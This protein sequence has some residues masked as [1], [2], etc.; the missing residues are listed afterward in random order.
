M[1]AAPPDAKPPISEKTEALQEARDSALGANVHSFDPDA[2]P[3]EKKA[4]ALK[5]ASNVTPLDL[6]AAPSLKRA[7]HEAFE[8]A[9][10]SSVSSDIGTKGSQIPVTTGL[11]DVQKVN[12]EE[13]SKEGEVS[14][15]DR[16]KEIAKDEGRVDEDGQDL[17]PGN[18][19]NKEAETGKPREIPSWF[20]I[21]WNGQ[22]QSLF[23]TPEESRQHAILADFVSEAYYGQWYVMSALRLTKYHNAG[24]IIFAVIASHFVTLFGGGWGWLIIVLAFCATYY[25][26]SIK[27][28]RRNARDDLARE[29]A[30]K[31]L[32]NEVETAAWINSFMQRF[33]LIYEPVLS[34]TI[35]A[36]VDQVLS[37]STPAFLDSLRMTTFTLGTKPPHIDHVRTFPDTEDDIV[38]MEWKVS[39]TPNDLTDMT[40]AQAAKKVNPKIVLQVRFGKGIASIGKDIVVEDIS[41]SGT[42]RVLLKLVNNFPHVQR[43]DLSFMQPP[44]FDFQLKPIGF[45]LSLIPGL[46]PFIRS[47]VHASLGPMLYH[48]NTFTL[49]LEQML[50]G[51][52]I[53]TAIGVLAVT[54]HIGRGLRGTKLGGGAPDPY[55][56]FSI[57]GRAE[58]ARTKVKKNTS[59]PRWT[60]TKYILL[61]SLNDTLNMTV[62]DFND[63]RQDSNIGAVSFDLKSLAEDA[64]QPNITG[65]VIYDGKP[66][67][68]LRYSVNYFPVL[69]PTKLADGTV[70][71]TPETTSGVV[72]LNGQ[73]IHRSQT[74]KRTTNP[75]WERPAEFLVTAKKDA[76]IGVA[77]LDDNTLLADSKLG[78]VS[79]RLNDILEAN[80]QG[81]DWFPLSHA[82]SGRIRLSA[83]WKPVLMAGAINGAGSYTPPIGVIRFHLKRSRDLKNV[84]GLTGGKSDPY[85]RISQRGIVVAR[86]V[87]HDNNLDPVYDEIVYTEVHGPKDYFVLEVMDYQHNGHDRSLG[88]VEYTISEL[89]TEGPDRKTKPW[90]GTGKVSKREMLKTHH[91]KNSVKGDLEFDAE[92]FPC[93]PLK[94]VSFTP[95]S[96]SVSSGKITEVKE[97][98]GAEDD[99]EDDDGAA[100]SVA[101]T[102]TESLVSPP[103]SPRKPTPNGSSAA[104]TNGAKDSEKDKEEDGVE[105]PR[106]QLLKMQTGVL[107]FQIISG[108]I[109]KKGAR[110]EVLFDDGYW[111]AFSTERSRSTHNTWDEI[112]EAVIR[113][114]DFSQIILKLNDSDK[115]TREDIVAAVTID[116]NEFL[117]Q[118]LDKPATFTLVSPEPG[119]PRSTVT[120]MSKYIP[121]DMQILPRESVNNSGVFRVEVLDAKGLPSADRNGKSDP[122]AVF[123]LNEERVHKTEVVKKTLAPV[124]NERFEMQVPSREAADFVVEVHDWDRV[125]TSDKLGRARIDLRD[126]EPF[127]A[128]ERTVALSDWK[129]ASKSAGS[130]RIRM[131][132]SPQFIYRSRRA[133]STFSAGRIGSTL[134][135]G[136]MAVGGGIVGAGGA[137]GK[138][139][140]G[141]VGTVGKVGVHG[142]GTVGKGVGHVGKGVFGA[143][144]RVVGGHGRHGSVASVSELAAL[145]GEPGYAVEGPDGVEVLAADMVEGPGVEGTLT[146]TV[147]QLVGGGDADEKKAV[148]VKFA[149]KTVHESH[150]HRGENG[151]A[152]YNETCTVKTPAQGPV[153]L[154][155]SV[156]HKKTFGSDKVLSSGVLSI[157]QH[158]SAETPNTMVTVPLT[159]S[160]NGSLTCQ[161]AW[162]AKPAFLSRTNSRAASEIDTRS[163]AESVSVTASPASKSRSRFSSGRFGRK[164]STPAPVAE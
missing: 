95:P 151:E 41:F 84:E 19:P 83:E 44:D 31:G 139:G 150:S 93:V 117:E 98:E 71:P 149:G 11:K 6:S 146:V 74:L 5:S 111:P 138:A 112:G 17:P 20:A 30:K 115:D 64:D 55:V 50:S 60:E 157:W 52:P 152:A 94:N 137:V 130:I 128:V 89:L 54:A 16:A 23:L 143:G 26:M 56:S 47:Q 65:E 123:V 104:G 126:I 86:T 35:V 113:E 73:S 25:E 77:V 87:I 88:L 81:N 129:D 101:E 33:W 148:V 134:G 125:G 162:L 132:F 116:L 155:F 100:A 21:G 68:I 145:D 24:V 142:V 67:G 108:N 124:W 156:V 42:M 59:T 51:A 3:A 158:I 131:V 114:L 109:S 61:N 36:S 40:H 121:I 15:A 2:T 147:G 122:Y 127:E 161:L 57:S 102:A 7:E 107:A 62:F 160:P 80:A 92:F 9:G 8:K 12:S 136:A 38:I 78:H 39:F 70:E 164:E 49:N 106:E 58:L 76:T 63:R 90:V 144:R 28:V 120:I 53:D 154:S 22:N 48:P 140:F 163:I 133:T 46:S 96:D 135:G 99:G 75:I 105:V 82:R 79:V 141:A 1:A 4:Q 14:A 97:D 18:M 103:T 91:S 85:V 32:R 13:K 66:R 72:Y 27:R 34:A 45:D 159:G 10:G 43:V 110:L 37:V 153:D 29:V 69:Q 118:T 119:G